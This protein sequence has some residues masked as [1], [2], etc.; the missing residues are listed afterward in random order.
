MQR[1]TIVRLKKL[2]VIEVAD[3]LGLKLTGSRD[4]QKMRCL[5]FMHTDH[6]PSLKFNGI[7]NVWRCFVCGV[8]GGPIDLVMAYEKLDFKDA[9]QRLMDEFHIYE[10]T[11]PKT[12][13]TARRQPRTQQKQLTKLDKENMQTSSLKYLD[14]T[15]IE[16][17]RSNDNSF[18]KAL[19]NSQILT[20][21]Q[22]CRAAERYRIGSTSK[23]G[24]IFWKIDEKNRLHDGKVMYYDDTCH[25]IKN[26]KNRN[27]MYYSWAM[28]NKMK[29]AKGRALLPQNFHAEQ[30]L[31]GL[32]LLAETPN[33]IDEKGSEKPRTIAIVESEKTAII[34]SE[35]MQSMGT[36]W[37]ATGGASCL[38]PAV[39]RP[40]KDYPVVLFP[41]TDPTG[42]SYNNWKQIAD[43]ASER[44]NFKYEIVVSNMLEMRATE[45]EKEAKIDIADYIIK[46][47]PNLLK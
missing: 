30:T 5:C 35:R 2:N 31:F 42:D 24:V 33:I 13:L 25:R 21:D 44:M 15:E 38:T 28:K 8:G 16:K 29:D 36:I 18:C 45:E 39:L 40:L 19:V 20:Y 41:D 10:Y 6:N 23:D 9:C 11:A 47:Y 37:M 14:N 26:D 43:E 7:R 4:S 1:D 27:T 34:C 12:V 3:K 46:Y 17:R 32:H 22:M